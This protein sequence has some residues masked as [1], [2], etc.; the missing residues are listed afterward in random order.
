MAVIQGA[1]VGITFDDAHLGGRG[2]AHV[3]FTMPAYTAVSDTGKLG[4]GGYLFGVA[5]TDS[6]ETILQSVRR[7][8]KT[9]NI[10]GAMQG[11]AGRHGSTE[12]FADTTAVSTN[13][14]TFEIANVGSTEIDAA[15]GVTDRPCEILVSY[16]LS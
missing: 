3:R 4:S 1:I 9:L 13:D 7:D 14:I 10:T 15:S 6:L 11:E 2:V 16:D 5:T 12:F 8:G